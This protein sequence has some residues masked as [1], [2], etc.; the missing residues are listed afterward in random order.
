VIAS[1]DEPSGGAGLG[2]ALAAARSHLGLVALLFALA[3]IGWWSAVGRMDGMDEGPWTGL[4]T[5]G[6]FLGVWVVMMAAMMLP[7][8]APTLALYARMTTERTPLLAWI[9]AA[10]YLVTW[11]GAG[12]LAF[13]IARGG[14]SAFSDVLAWDRAGRWVAG[15]TLLVA[16]AYEL[17]PLK[18]VC[19]YRCRSPLGFLLG[20]WRDGEAGAL[21]MGMRHGAWCVGCCWALMA[22][23]FALG[24]MS[25]AW[26]AFVAGLIALEKLL[27]WRRVATWATAAVLLVLGVL[28]LTSPGA[29]PALTI[30][31][32]DSKPQMDHMQQMGRL[33]G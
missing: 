11:A 2:P 21:G 4:G 25:I 26:M 32:H 16:A 23:L 9:F 27:P 14:G 30:P 12:A 1:A 5:L 19:L 18:N 7:S 28:L 24:V 17:T 3:A 6:W 22:S 8:V 13:A 20:S 33:P 31:G 10:G 29:V 15:T